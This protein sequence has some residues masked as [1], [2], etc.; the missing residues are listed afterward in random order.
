MRNIFFKSGR[1]KSKQINLTSANHFIFTQRRKD[2]KNRKEDFGDYILGGS[3][4]HNSSNSNQ[5]HLRTT[6]AIILIFILSSISAFSQKVTLVEYDS[7][8]SG[9]QQFEEY[10]NLLTNKKVALVANQASIVGEQHL[11]DFLLDK[12]VEIIRVFSPEHGF[13]GKKDAGE[14]V[15]NETDSKTGIQIISLYGKHK[16]PTAEDLQGVEVVVFDLQDVGV[17]FYTYIST[18]TYVMEACAENNTPLI[19]LDRPN[20]NAFCIDG[21][22]LEP[23]FKSFVGMHPVPV[24][25]GMTIGEYAKMVNG[26][27]WLNNQIQCKLTVIPL[28]NYNHNMIVKLPI[29]PS[30]NLPNW[31]SVYLYPSLCFFEGTTVSVGRGTDFPFQAYG[32]PNLKYGSFAFTP[33]PNQGAKNPK[34]NGELCYGQFLVRY[35]ENYQNNPAAINLE[36]LIETYKNIGQTDAAFFKKYFNT[37]AGNSRLRE[38]IENGFSPERI[39]QSW[40]NGIEDFKKIREKYLIYD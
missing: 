23:E 36:W 29:R 3:H 16:K 9:A 18:L 38:Q 15:D 35:A 8:A 7:I 6:L 28:K 17:R 20:P 22:I 13:R 4:N 24:V 40:Q 32:H 2:T 39:K 34:H 26:E 30:P 10:K 5:S 27:K 37:L 1:I 11:V 12:N 31:Q 33:R 25:Y 21:P 14:K 19:L